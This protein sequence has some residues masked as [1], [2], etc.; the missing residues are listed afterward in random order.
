MFPPKVTA[1]LRG[2][3]VGALNGLREILDQD[4]Y[5]LGRHHTGWTISQVV[6]GWWLLIVLSWSYINTLNHLDNYSLS[7]QLEYSVQLL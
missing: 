7:A 2:I 6:F 1:L 3:R 4:S 5:W